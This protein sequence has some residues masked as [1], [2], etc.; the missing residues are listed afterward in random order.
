LSL[1]SIPT[2]RSIVG[3][4]KARKLLR[5]AHR[6]ILCIEDIDDLGGEDR[7]ELLIAAS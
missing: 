1:P 7:L 4:R 6:D 5:A 3:R 2:R